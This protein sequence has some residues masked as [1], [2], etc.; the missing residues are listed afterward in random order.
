MNRRTFISGSS[1]LLICAGLPSLSFGNTSECWKG[2]AVN[3]STLSLLENPD[4][5]LVKVKAGQFSMGNDQGDTDAK[6][7]HQVELTR[8]FEIGVREVTYGE[9]RQFRLPTRSQRDQKAF[10]RCPDNPVVN[11]SWYDAVEFCNWLSERH[12]LNPCYSSGG[13]ATQCNFSRNGYRL[14]TEAEWEY[15]AKGGHLSRG[16]RFAGSD[17]PLEVA[18]FKANGKGSIYP[19]GLKKP[20]ELGLFNMSGNVWNWCWDW[21]DEDNYRQRAENKSLVIDP[22]GPEQPASKHRW[23]WN[24]CR[25]GG[26]FQS[27]E[28]VVTNT[29]RSADETGYHSFANGFRVVR[30]VID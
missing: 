22:V 18:W 10:N 19:A 9:Y 6:P 29:F 5:L 23:M 12:G 7:L 3:N 28:N 20:N 24:R 17:D 14:P 2:R 16:F 27:A 1:Y 30:T 25:R 11:I 8:N 15:A 13:V 4:D 21:Y 26:D